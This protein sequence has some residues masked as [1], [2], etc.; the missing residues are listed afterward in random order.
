MKFVL[1]R[2]RVGVEVRTARGRIDAVVEV[3]ERVYIFEFKLGGSEEEAL[4]QIKER[5]YAEKY[6]GEG[7]EI[8]LVGVGFGMEERNIAGWKVEVIPAGR[9][10][11]ASIGV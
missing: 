2:M 10:T 7:K 8:V 4:R 6:R 11:N 5:G 1:T 9:S 3:G